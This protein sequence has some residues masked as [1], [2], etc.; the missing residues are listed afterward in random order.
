MAKKKASGEAPTRRTATTIHDVAR[1]LGVSSM[2]VSRVVNG[3]EGVKPEL[4]ERVLSGIRELNYVP[5][6]AARAARA[7]V[8]RIGVLFS[9][10]RSSNLGEFLMGAFTASGKIGCQLVVE[11]VTAHP[12]PIDAVRSVVAAGVDAVIL[13][14]PLCDSTE[15]LEIVWRA[16][17]PAI[18]FAT[19]EPRSHSSAVFIDDFGG[20]R[21]MTRH[22]ID[23]GHRD[24]AFV[25]GN[26]THSPGRRREEGFRAAMAEAGLAVPPNRLVQGMF[27]YRSGLEVGKALLECGPKERPTAIFASNDDMAAGILAVALGLG[28]KIP[29]ELSV[30]GF[31]DAPIAGIIWPPLTTIHQPIAEMASTAVTLAHNMVRRARSEGSVEVTHHQC[32]LSLEVRGSTG[33]AAGKRSFAKASPGRRRSSA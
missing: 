26:P 28:I 4:R 9:N 18:S 1:H 25:L 15:A 31:D 5:N 14:P 13:P 33:P 20:A 16:Q 19:A 2:T 30:A 12:D 6:V 3:A 23:L 24:I 22:L 21:A 32:K 11:P 29:A 27:T 17:L 7:G 10:P 8:I